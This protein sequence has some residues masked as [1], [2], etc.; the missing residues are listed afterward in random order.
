[1]HLMAYANQHSD[2]RAELSFPAE[3]QPAVGSID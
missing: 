1:M 3:M 2:R